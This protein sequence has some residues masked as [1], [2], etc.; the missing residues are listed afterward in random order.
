MKI[1]QLERR[2]KVQ[3]DEVSCIFVRAS[4]VT[5]AR[6]LAAEERIAGD[7]GPE[8]WKSPKTSSCKEVNQEGKSKVLACM[9]G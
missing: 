9:F 1:Y 5:Q 6:A 8:V 4:S 3:Y 7:E 2:D